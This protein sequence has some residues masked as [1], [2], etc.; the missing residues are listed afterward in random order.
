[1]RRSDLHDPRRRAALRALAAGPAALRGLALVPAALLAPHARA[2]RELEV[3][4]VQSPL[5]V[6][7]AMLALGAVGRDDYLIDLGSGDG[8]IVI[9]AAQRFG[10]RGLGVEID[11]RLVHESRAAA[12]RA[13][14]ARLVEFRD[15][16]L[17]RTDL[18]K[19]SVVTMYLLPTVNL[20]LRPR[21]LSTLRPGSRVVSHDWDMGDWEPDGRIVVAAPE[22]KV[23]LEKRSTI[24]A[25]VV[26][27]PVDGR[28]SWRQ[29]ADRNGQH[30]VQ[31]LMNLEQRYQK[32][33]GEI[34]AGTARFPIE[35]AKLDGDRISL[36][37]RLPFGARV[38]PWTF[39]GVARGDRIDGEALPEAGQPVK[40]SAVRV[41]RAAE[42]ATGELG[43]RNQP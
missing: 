34:I 20:E 17:F 21:L 30:E 40:W 29:A 19:A 7:D 15:E 13:G 31:V 26:P 18:S 28:W 41:A 10:T 2:W 5:S 27:A 8:R 37:T 6:V 39:R 35:A 24:F 32:V 3:P 25:W 22:K 12:E 42:P 14:V 1:V 38:R 9:A 43:G 33:S 23:G 4:Y 36:R 11:T 16:D